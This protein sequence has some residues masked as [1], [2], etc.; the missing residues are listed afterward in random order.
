[1]RFLRSILA[2]VLSAAASGAVAGPVDKDKCTFKGH[3]LFG[4]VQFVEI[5]RCRS[6][7]R[8]RT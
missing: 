7:S 4:K 5:S 2:A 8:F 3:K 1:V 6:S